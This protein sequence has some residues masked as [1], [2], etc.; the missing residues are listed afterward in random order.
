MVMVETVDIASVTEHPVLGAFVGE[1][2]KQ[3][4]PHASFSSFSSL[5]D[6]VA[7]A[8]VAKILVVGVGVGDVSSNAMAKL[9][10]LFE[11]S[12]FQQALVHSAPKY[13]REPAYLASHRIVCLPATASIRELYSAFQRLLVQVGLHAPLS[14]AVNRSRPVNEFQSKVARDASAR[15]L[16]NRQVEIMELMSKGHSAKEAAR[17]LG[18]SPDTVRGHLKD[19][20]SRLC[21]KNIAQAVEVYSQARRFSEIMHG[22]GDGQE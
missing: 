12:L 4:A 22:G 2:C 20:F 11:E 7:S 16:T 6:F 17:T 18:I 1:L 14:G 9:P 10:A 5:E 19:T 8:N 15:P 13:Y 21:V 3:L